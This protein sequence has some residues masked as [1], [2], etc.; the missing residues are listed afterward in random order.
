MAAPPEARVA[1]VQGGVDLWQQGQWAAAVAMWRP[2]A[3]AGNTDAMF[4]MGQAYQLGR[5]VP[6]DEA[7]ALR[8]YE[9]AAA[10]G[11]RPALANQGILLFKAGRKTQ[12]LALLKRAADGGEPRAQFVYG[13]AAWNGDGL[14]RN[15]GIAYAYLARSAEQGLAEARSALDLLVPRLSLVERANG[16]Q[17]ASTLAREDGTRGPLPGMSAGGAAGVV[18]LDQVADQRPA[19]QAGSGAEWRVQIGAFSNR[20][21]AEA[22]LAAIRSRSPA[23]LSG[24]TVFFAPGGSLVRLQLG[25][26]ESADAARAGCARFAAVGRSC[27]VVSP[28]PN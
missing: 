26:F 6:R 28:A 17:L 23:V 3:D 25:P 22:D 13:T 20:S 14:E 16:Q 10:R 4:N 27:L 8:W 19:A 18:V 12:A 7:V 11:H 1:S 21:G 9:Q 15:L 24:L 5:G 2:F